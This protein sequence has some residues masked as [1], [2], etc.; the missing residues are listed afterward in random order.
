MIVT[1]TR[2]YTSSLEC[3]YCDIGHR[4]I[5]IN[6]NWAVRTKNWIECEMDFKAKFCESFLVALL[7]LLSLSL[8]F[9]IIFKIKAILL[10]IVYIKQSRE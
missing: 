3:C 5:F 6:T 9:K 4:K 2:R 1:M 7:L 8:L 10:T